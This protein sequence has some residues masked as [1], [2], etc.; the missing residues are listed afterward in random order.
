[1]LLI[2]VLKDIFTHRKNSDFKGKS[3]YIVANNGNPK[4]L[5]VGGGSK[6]IPIPNHYGNWDHILLD[7]DPVSNADVIL[8]ARDLTS[9]PTSSFDAVYCSHNLEH[10]YRHDATKVLAGFLHVLKP[11][12]FVE[13]HV[14]DIQSVM[15]RVIK[16]KLD[17]SDTL[18]QSKNG[19]ISVHDVIYGWGKQIESSG[20][21]FYAHKAGFSR[22][23]LI[24]ALKQAG[25]SHVK[26]KANAESYELS[27]FAC[28]GDP[29][30]DLFAIL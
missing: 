23:T 14:P 12:G 3:E 19:P 13:I 17:I 21:D 29:C 15:S 1:M 9:F 2:N 30:G 11:G 16:S 6:L 28:K 4:V 27:A 18:Y 7:I 8:D 24:Q 5:N 10:Y 22:V 20:V 26:C 25:F